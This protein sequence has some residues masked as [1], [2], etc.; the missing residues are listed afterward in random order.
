MQ[1]IITF[2]LAAVMCFALVGCGSSNNQIKDEPK[3]EPYRKVTYGMSF[4]EVKETEKELGGK[5]IEEDDTRILYSANVEGETVRIVY[6]FNNGKLEYY[7]IIASPDHGTK[8][9]LQFHDDLLKVLDKSYSTLEKDN[10]TYWYN[11]YEMVGKTFVDEK[12]VGK[13]VI[14]MF[15]LKENTETSN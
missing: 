4:E 7:N 5:F 6:R 15:Q 11:S 10:E 2:F 13:S 3:D 1:R 12:Y 9:Y 8:D 14:F